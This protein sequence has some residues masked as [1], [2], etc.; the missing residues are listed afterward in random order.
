MKK[1][2][3]ILWFMASALVI[4]LALVVGYRAV[5]SHSHLMQVD[6]ELHSTHPLPATVILGTSHAA[7]LDTAIIPGSLN[8]SGYGEQLHQTWFK[9][10]R[11]IENR[12][13]PK[14][15]VISCDLG[16]LHA[17]RPDQQAYQWYWNRLE[18]SG[19]IGFAKDR[20]TY[21]LK[22]VAAT[23]VPY[24]HG[25]TDFID[26]YSPT[27]VPGVLRDGGF[28][29]PA[30]QR[31]PAD[32][33]LNAQTSDYGE[34][35]LRKLL[36]QC[37]EDSTEV[38]LVRFPVTDNYYEYYSRCFDP[39]QYYRELDLWIYQLGIEPHWIDLHDAFPESDFRDA[40][41]LQA[42]APREGLSRRVNVA[43]E[44]EG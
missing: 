12:G 36:K 4:H 13:A 17:H 23:L 22:R 41:H 8:I 29:P 27:D 7:A 34:W 6:R 44:K 28:F 32:S 18:G 38:Y 39:E 2:N 14:R 24:M 15:I 20:T 31:I 37:L 25:E 3:K 33:C 19:L 42:G 43:L 21:R 10:K 40:H 26:R 5:M 16:W 1:R 9:Y 11:L 35:Y 30:P